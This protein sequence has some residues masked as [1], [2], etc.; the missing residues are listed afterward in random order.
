MVVAYW[1]QGLVLNLQALTFHQF[2]FVFENIIFNFYLKKN[3]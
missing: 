1:F 3:I 2:S